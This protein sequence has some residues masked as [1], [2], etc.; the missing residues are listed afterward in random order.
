ME[1]RVEVF[2]VE[3]LCFQF[4]NARSK[5]LSAVL[6]GVLDWIED[7]GLMLNRSGWLGGL[8]RRDRRF[9]DHLAGSVDVCELVSF[10]SSFRLPVELLELCRNGLLDRR[11]WLRYMKLGY[12][13]I[14]SGRDGV[15]RA[16]GNVFVR[17]DGDGFRL[18]FCRSLDHR[19]AL[20]KL[21]GRDGIDAVGSR[22]LNG[23]VLDGNCGLL[24]DRLDG[25]SDQCFGYFFR[26]RKDADAIGFVDYFGAR[27]LRFGTVAELLP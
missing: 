12:R 25:W 2:I 17:L 26:N 16:A 8:L 21:T 15:N 13:L 1:R 24:V 4:A 19:R 6:N 5:D 20:A 18:L 23:L 27:L 3:R 9:R 11:L 14:R 7:C 22:G 10:G